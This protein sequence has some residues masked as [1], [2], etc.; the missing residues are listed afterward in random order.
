MRKSA[1]NQ[2]GLARKLVKVMQRQVLEELFFH[3]DPHPADLVVM[4]NNKI[5]FLK[6]GAVGRFTTQ[7]RKSIREFQYHMIKGDIGR[8]ANVALSLLGPLPPMDVESV[9]HE[10]EKIYSD[11]VY[12]MKSDDAEWWEE[13]G[14]GM[15]AF[16]RGRTQV[17]HSGQRRYY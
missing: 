4:P 3:A 12:A 1:S 15:A 7:T 14:P 13:L 5:C 10:L 2:K 8:L 16:S 17:L 9:R 6:F 11:A